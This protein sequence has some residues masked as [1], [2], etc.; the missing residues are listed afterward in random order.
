MIRL[1]IHMTDASWELLLS[2]K[3]HNQKFYIGFCLKK[4]ANF[5]SGMDILILMLNKI[6]YSLRKSL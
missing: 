6:F 4:L 1:D 2:D 5:Y 3:E